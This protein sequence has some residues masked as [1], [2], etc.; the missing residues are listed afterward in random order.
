M[1]LNI[2]IN[3]KLRNDEDLPFK[4]AEVAKSGIYG[5]THSQSIKQYG[6][7]YE[8]FMEFYKF[9]TLQKCLNKTQNVKQNL[10]LG[11]TEVRISDFGVG[12]NM[13]IIKRFV[14][15]DFYISI[16]IIYSRFKFYSQILYFGSG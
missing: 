16:C 12:R 6:S 3:I 1:E 2:N 11:K 7:T 14:I 10:D 5:L 4:A 15:H 13:S 8:D 9:K